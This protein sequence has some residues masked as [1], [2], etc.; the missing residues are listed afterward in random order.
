[1][2]KVTNVNIDCTT[3][4]SAQLLFELKA[5]LLANGWTLVASSDGTNFTNGAAPDRVPTVAL[6]NLTSAYYVL[7]DPAGLCWLYVQRGS[8]NLNA[9]IKVSRVAP[10]ANGTATVMP[11]TAVA[12]NEKTILNATSFAGGGGSPKGHIITY[13][14]AENLAGVRPV[15]VLMTDGLPTLRGAFCIEAAADNTYASANPYPWAAAHATGNSVFSSGTEWTYYYSPTSVFVATDVATAV[16]SSSAGG[17]IAGSSTVGPDP[18]NSQDSGLPIALGRNTA[19]TQPGIWGYMKNLR[20]RTVARGYPDTMTTA[21]GER[22]V[23]AGDSIVP[24]ANGVTPG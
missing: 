12:A 16:P 19:A 15:Y 5:F 20:A 18:W 23:Y 3:N 22:Y 7:A 2:A 14:A 8:S 17:Y 6:F 9:T 11:T 1:M 13:D 4:Q 24:Y 21:G 10:Q